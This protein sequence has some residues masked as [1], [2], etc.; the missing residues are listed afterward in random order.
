MPMKLEL[1]KPGAVWSSVAT[2]IAG[3]AYCLAPL[4]GGDFCLAYGRRCVIGGA[5]GGLPSMW[6]GQP[7]L[8]AGGT[9]IPNG[10]LR[11]R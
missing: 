5:I 6:R 4:C 11:R 1:P 3:A 8:I 2:A 9:S 10:K 7:D